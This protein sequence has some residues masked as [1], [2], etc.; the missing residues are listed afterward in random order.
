M[1]HPALAAAA[2]ALLA[3]ILF[4]WGYFPWTDTKPSE[5]PVL[6]LI[7]DTGIGLNSAVI[8]EGAE[9]AARAR[10]AELNYA[11]PSEFEGAGRQLKLVTQWMDEGADAILLKPISKDVAESAA[12]LCAARDV[13][14]VF[15]DAFKTYRGSAPYVGTD[16][17]ASG[18][19]AADALIDL[20]GSK[21][22]MIL[23]RQG[24]LYSERLQGVLSVAER[25]GVGAEAQAIK[26]DD[27]F[28]Q[29]KQVGEII[30]RMTEP[31][32]VLCL[33]GVLTNFAAD[34]LRERDMQDQIALAGFDCDQAHIDCLVDETARFTVLRAPLAIGYGGVEC[35]MDLVVER[36]TKPV[37]YVDATVIMSGEAL[38]SKYAH[39]MFPLIH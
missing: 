20:S 3:V 29:I 19:M 35:A 27:P 9:I 37:Q 8:R 26:A 11:V 31:S 18:G 39:L 22:L 30:G 7:L 1:K 5:G 33:D 38:D 6:A 24:S 36:I 10:G 23:Y 21:R 15:L 32:A 14:L 34:I 16:H 12:R 28:A 2:S 25:K 13:P 17:R 4:A